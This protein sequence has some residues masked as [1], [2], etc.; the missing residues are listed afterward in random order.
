M[1]AC[2]D[3]TDGNHVLYEFEKLALSTNTDK[4]IETSISDI[5]QVVEEIKR[6]PKS[7]KFRKSIA[8]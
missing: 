1:C 2:E 5:I 3:F 7:T 6:K 8:K 4:K